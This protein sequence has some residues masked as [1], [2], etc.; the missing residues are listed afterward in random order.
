MKKNVSTDIKRRS[1]RAPNVILFDLIVFFFSI[2][3]FYFFFLFS[4]GP[5]F[6]TA[7]STHNDGDKTPLTLAR[8]SFSSR[9]NV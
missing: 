5:I 8:D 2:G 4:F 1:V 6:L 7:A 3:I 9:I